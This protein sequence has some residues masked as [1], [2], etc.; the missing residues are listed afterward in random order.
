[1]SDKNLTTVSFPTKLLKEV[2]GV[3]TES[4]KYMSRADFCRAAVRRL[5]SEEGCA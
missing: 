2:D 4:G 1:M 3:V 5:I